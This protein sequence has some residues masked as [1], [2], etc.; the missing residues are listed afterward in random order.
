VYAISSGA[1]LALA[2]A[3]A[4]P[5]IAKLAVYEPPFMAEV[6]DGARIKEYT[7]R[8]NELLDA[9]RKGDAVALFMTNVGIPAQAVAG[10]R[11]QPGWAMLEVI[12]PTLAYDAEV[13]GDGRVPR[14]LASTI[15]VP[16]LVLAGGTSPQSLQQAAK[17]T[18]D[19]LPT[20]EHRT[21][22]GQTHDVAPAVLAPVLAEFF[23]A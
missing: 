19:A 6:E 22:D 11:E 20:A 16:A 7:E 21:L 5:G 8:L 10:I 3:A 4:G 15:A 2:T 1:A 23:G 17:A 9:G 13:L 18:A 14:A 12:A